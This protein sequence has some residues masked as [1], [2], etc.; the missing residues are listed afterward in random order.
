METENHEEGT[1]EAKYQEV[2]LTPNVKNYDPK[3]EFR[4]KHVAGGWGHT[5]VIT[6]NFSIYFKF[7]KDFFFFLIRKRRNFHVGVQ[8]QRTIRSW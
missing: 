7:L 8:C 3:D 5:A 2:K 6:G 4:V 1:H